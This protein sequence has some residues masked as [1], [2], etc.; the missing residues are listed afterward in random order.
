MPS[1]EELNFIHL[2]SSP[3]K[4]NVFQNI[5]VISKTRFACLTINNRNIISN[6]HYNPA[7]DY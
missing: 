5:H 6:I 3:Q 2:H 4:I 1:V 7:H